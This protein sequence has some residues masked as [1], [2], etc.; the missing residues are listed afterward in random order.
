[1]THD[2]AAELGREEICSQLSNWLRLLELSGTREILWKSEGGL[3]AGPE[4]VL[5][6][7]L[8]DARPAAAEDASSSK[9]ATPVSPSLDSLRQKMACCTRCELHTTRTNVVFGEGSPESELI[10]IGE[11]PGRDEDL[12]GRPFVGRA[13]AL[14]TRIIEAMGLNR[15][16]VYIAN[17]VK[18]RPP[19]NRNPEPDEVSECLPFLEEQV[20]LIGPRVICSLGNV[21]T[22]TLTGVRDGITRMRGGSYEYRD[23]QVIPTF[24]PAACLRNPGIKKDVWEDIKKIMKVLGL[25]NRGVMRDGASKNKR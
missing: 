6:T 2:S 25:S 22:Q 15:E 21:A 3:E 18:C 4:M 14:L 19:G 23:I 10:F 5:A 13:G 12:S 24:H 17:I 1:M 20:D 16:D 11:G 7:G 8:D 9:S